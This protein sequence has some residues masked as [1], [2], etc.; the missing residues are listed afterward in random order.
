MQEIIRSWHLVMLEQIPSPCDLDAYLYICTA[1][2]TCLYYLSLLLSKLFALIEKK[3]V[4]PSFQ[5]FIRA[6]RVDSYMRFTASSIIGI[7][8]WWIYEYMDK[9]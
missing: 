5:I 1:G 7:T 3:T 4:L 2:Q 6:N 9:V 8:E